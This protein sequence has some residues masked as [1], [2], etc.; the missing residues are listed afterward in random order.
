MR[1]PLG[2]LQGHLS[3][4]EPGSGSQRP[5]CCPAVPSRSSGA[6]P[7]PIQDQV[8]PGSPPRGSPLPFLSVKEPNPTAR[9]TGA[10]SN[11][12]SRLGAQSGR[13]CGPLRTARSPRRSP[14]SSSPGPSAARRAAPHRF[15]PPRF[16]RT[17]FS[18]LSGLP[19][20]LF[21]HRGNCCISMLSVIR[22]VICSVQQH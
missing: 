17:A 4:P 15:Q 22:V 16:P 11:F 1:R 10:P 21:S 13:P 14:L 9:L 8:S 12:L 7:P 3:H 2:P 20:A 19:V 18:L 5:L 6:D